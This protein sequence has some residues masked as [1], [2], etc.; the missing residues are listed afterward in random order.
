MPVEKLPPD[1]KFA[2]LAQRALARG[3]LCKLHMKICR[4]N[5]MLKP[6][7][8][9]YWE[10]SKLFRDA[11]RALAEDRMEIIIGTGKKKSVPNANAILEQLAKLNKD[12]IAK[13]AEML[14]EVKK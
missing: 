8:L 10:Q 11:D 2:L 12:Q 6:L 9:R 1:K 5:K 7:Q 4:I 13:V 3:E 14:S